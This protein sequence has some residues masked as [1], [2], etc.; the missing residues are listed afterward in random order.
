M[1]DVNKAYDLPNPP[2]WLQERIEQIRRWIKY[3]KT[4]QPPKNGT[5]RVSQD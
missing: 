3:L 1:R 2:N 5:V 4:F